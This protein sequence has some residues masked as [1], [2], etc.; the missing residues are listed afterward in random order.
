MNTIAITGASGFVGTSLRNFFEKY[1]YKVVSIKREILDDKIELQNIVSSSQIVINL[2]GANIINRWT[3]EYKE[4][5]YSSRIDTTSKL[6]EAIN[7]VE[8]K[9]KLLISTSA[10]GIYDN[11]DTYTED[12]KFADDFLSKLCQ[13]WEEE[14]KKAQTKVSIF[15]FGI[16]L[17]KNGGAL[18]KMITPFKLG[19][20]GVIGSG[21]QAFSFIHI[22]D[23]LNAY[24]FVIDNNLAD[25]FNLTAPKPTTNLGLTRALGKALKKPTIF[26]VPEF[27]LKL[28]FSEG[29]KVLTDG[30]DVV[31][32]KLLDLGF[33]FKHKDIQE[34]VNSLV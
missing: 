15:R 31:P 11:K 28:I 1:G 5:L 9:P 4:L 19:L 27:V 32:K 12:G 23:L 26:P 30:Q 14:A 33:E 2:A 22:D 25:T 6:V 7:S 21:N 10:V 18:A 24:K 20:G 16:V 13:R 34:T 8:T 17:G 3:K 29:A